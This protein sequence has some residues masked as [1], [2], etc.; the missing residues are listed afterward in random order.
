M[1]DESLLFQNTIF[2][3]PDRKYG[4]STRNFRAALLHLQ[5]W[6]LIG[7]WNDIPDYDSMVLKKNVCRDLLHFAIC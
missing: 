4:L 5:R 2:F 6:L 1:E 3:D 7:P